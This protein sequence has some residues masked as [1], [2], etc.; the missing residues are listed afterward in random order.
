MLSDL[1]KRLNVLVRKKGIHLAERRIETI[2]KRVVQTI[3][4]WRLEV[5]FLL[6]R[7]Y[8]GKRNISLWPMLRTGALSKSVPTFKVET[9]KTFRGSGL[10]LGEAVISLGRKPHRVPWQTYGEELNQWDYPGTQLTNWKDRAYNMLQDAV[11]KKIKG[12]II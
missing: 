9:R 7:P 11:H 1:T 6:S 12:S 10:N 3:K 4:S 2:R 5:K 8:N